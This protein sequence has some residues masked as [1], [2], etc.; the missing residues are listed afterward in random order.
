MYQLALLIFPFR[1]DMANATGLMEYN[2][3]GCH[4]DCT[5]HLNLGDG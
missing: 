1:G 5:I 3:N 4:I 2:L